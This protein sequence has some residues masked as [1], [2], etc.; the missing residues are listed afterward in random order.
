[1]AKLFNSV[2]EGIALRAMCSR[3]PKI[4]GRFLGAVDESF[5]YNE[6]SIEAYQRIRKLFDSKGEPPNFKLLCEDLGLSSSAREFLR[7]VE[8]S[9]R[10]LIQAD[11]LMS[12]LNTYRKTRL[13]YTLAK[14]LLAKLE[15]NRVD[16]DEVVDLVQRRL[17]RLQSKSGIEAD[18]IHI[19]KDSNVLK[20]VEE[21]LYEQKDDRCIPTG[22][23][24]W[25]ERNGGFFR[26]NLVCIGGSSGGGK[27][28]LAGQLNMNHAAIGYKTA[29]AP[30]EMTSEEMLSRSLSSLSGVNSTDIFLQRV[31]DGERDMIYRKMRRFD[32]A[33]AAAGGRFTIFKP[34]ED[35]T[36]EELLASLH[37]FNSDLIYID[38]IGL[39]KGADGDDQWRKLGQIARYCKIYAESHKKV[40]V[41][42]AQVSE[43]GKLKY[44]Q[45]IKEHANLAWIF[46]ATKE[47]KEKGYLNI[48][49]L[50]SRNQDPRPFTLKCD[51]AKMRVSD[52]EPSELKEL[53]R[54]QEQKENARRQGSGTSKVKASESGKSSDYVPDLS[55]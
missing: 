18:V 35:M 21:L 39:L 2:T 31:A 29:L 7:N 30:L 17:V 8:S 27:S 42:L 11:Q 10:T 14:G 16:V 24:T 54:F 4:A 38:Y 40:V 53:E 6:E 15:K 19:G 25:D 26:G 43:E 41:L 52:L 28:I 36:A 33:A 55:E 12:Q 48:E 46:V 44:S 13:L 45:T 3:D 51:Y 5:F 22:F 20:A 47:T 9:P 34:R 37:T 1:M 49:L 50:K 23:K 32:K